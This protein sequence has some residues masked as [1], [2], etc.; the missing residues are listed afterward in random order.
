MA[1]KN[2]LMGLGMAHMLA[3]IIGATPT[4][5][6]IAGS[7]V[8]S[9]TQMGG[10]DYFAVPITGTSGLKLP[11]IGG[12]DGILLTTPVVVMNMTAAAI[13]LFASSNAAGSAVSMFLNGTSAAGSTGMSL[14][15]GH[16][17]ILWAGSVSTWVGI[18]T[19]V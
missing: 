17:A 11:T 16:G 8:G 4:N 3:G 13:V 2:D 14:L 15:S 6:I 19:S 9:A 10:Q 18:K 5:P 1:T 7:T 12:G